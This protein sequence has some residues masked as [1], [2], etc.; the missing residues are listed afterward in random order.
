MK[1]KVGIDWNRQSKYCG[2]TA[3][4]VFSNISLYGYFTFRYN[5]IIKN[6]VCLKAVGGTIA[7]V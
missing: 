1:D 7:V 3:I 4:Q 5:K 6:V 2:G